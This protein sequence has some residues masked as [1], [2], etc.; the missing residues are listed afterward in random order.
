M[1][2]HNTKDQN[3]GHKVSA[4]LAGYSL[5]TKRE[6]TFEQRLHTD[7]FFGSGQTKKHIDL[8]KLGLCFMSLEEALEAIPQTTKK[9]MVDGKL[10]EVVNKTNENWAMFMLAWRTFHA[11]NTG[12]P[13][14][15]IDK[16]KPELTG[17]QLHENTKHYKAPKEF[18]DEYYQTIKL[19]DG[20]FKQIKHTRK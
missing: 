7:L 11:P 4:D 19:A 20:T 6:F 1:Q 17:E 16:Y 10:V 18:K 5:P 3:K 2:Y 12:I 15:Y 13:Q 8:V 9:A 14:M